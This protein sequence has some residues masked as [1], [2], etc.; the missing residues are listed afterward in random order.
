M[1]KSA[2]KNYTFAFSPSPWSNPNSKRDRA[3]QFI[4][5]HYTWEQIA[6]QLIEVYKEICKKK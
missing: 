1:S 5:N 6:S 2:G 4:L 3:R